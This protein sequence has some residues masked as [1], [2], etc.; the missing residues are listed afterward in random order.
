MSQTQWFALNILFLSHICLVASSVHDYKNEHF[1]NLT[2]AFIFNGGSEGMW[3]SVDKTVE[4]YGSSFIRFESLTFKRTAAAAAKFSEMQARTQQIEAIVFEVDDRDK[5]GGKDGQGKHVLCCTKD[6]VTTEA[7]ELGE[8]IKHS[9]DEWPKSIPIYF[10]GNEV[11]TRVS[12]ESIEIKK[13]GMY[14][15][16][17]IFCDPGLY[18]TVVNGKTIWKNPTG[19]LPG[20]LAP[21]MKFYGFL[22]LAYVILGLVWLV[23]YIRFWRDILQLQNYITL[24]IALGMCEMVLWYF[25]YTNFNS[26]GYRP[27]I[28]TL[29]AVTFGAVKKT[30]SRCLLLVVSMGY[31]VVRPTLGG[32][33]LRVLVL[34]A[35]YFVAA[36]LL[37]VVENVGTINDLSGKAKLFLVLPVAILDAVF[38]L[39]IFT[40]LSKTL[41]KLQARRIMAKLE[42]YRKF[43]NSLA[44]VVVM[45]IAWIGYELFFKATDPFG[46]RWQSAWIIS[47]F[48]N[49]VTFILLCI[50]CSLWSPSKNAMRYAYSEEVHDDFDMEET[51]ALTSIGTNVPGAVEVDREKRSIN[52][53]VFSL[54]EDGGEDKI[55]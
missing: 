50:I 31:G 43:T 1:L 9:A 39:W 14:K 6:L 46:E 4:S 5:I 32:L 47:A 26:T 20:R 38:I 22:S 15:L 2:N 33:T 34:G 23:Q 53:D 28:I 11:E 44:V 35:A 7:C 25:E 19:Y 29:W 17:F 40:S 37:D 18:G 48:W 49:V 55:E 21:L 13:T 3:T 30:V 52:T 36:E 27:V 8:V 42:L 54:E 10:R 45:S 16:Y 12:S 41:E 51:I 24:V